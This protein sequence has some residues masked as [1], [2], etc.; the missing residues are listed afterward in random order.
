MLPTYCILQSKKCTA[1]QVI[2]NLAEKIFFWKAEV[3]EVHAE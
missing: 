3:S 2:T 1:Q